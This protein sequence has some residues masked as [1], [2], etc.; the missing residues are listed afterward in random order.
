MEKIS[1]QNYD[2]IM[3]SKQICTRN[4]CFLRHEKKIRSKYYKNNLIYTQISQI[5]LYY[6]DQ[7]DFNSKKASFNS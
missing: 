4:G 1:R 6:T 2:F 5:K 7:I 3:S